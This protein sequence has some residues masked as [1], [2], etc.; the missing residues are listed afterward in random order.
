MARIKSRSFQHKPQHGPEAQIEPRKSQD[1][2]H[3]TSH[4]YS[5]N[6]EAGFVNMEADLF[7]QDQLCMIERALP[8]MP[9]PLSGPIRVKDHWSTLQTGKLH[10][11]RAQQRLNQPTRAHVSSSST[12]YTRLRHI[13][14]A[15]SHTLI[16]AWCIAAG[17]NVVMIDGPLDRWETGKKKKKIRTRTGRTGAS[18][19]PT[20]HLCSGL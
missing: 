4:T 18:P 11:E 7:C 10:T 12:P 13:S 17:G 8:I 16:A 6:P 19:Q 3:H 2:A 15:A 20:L 9:S 5:R 1:T 14:S